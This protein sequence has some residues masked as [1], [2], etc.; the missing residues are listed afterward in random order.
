MLGAMWAPAKVLATPLVCALAVVSLAAC[1][2]EAEPAKSAPPS[3]TPT[4]GATELRA[5]PQPYDVTFASVA[6]H[7]AKGT[8]EATLRAVTRP[9]RTWMDSGFV[10][11]PWP[12]DGF[13]AAF[14][15]FAGGVESKARRDADLLTLRRTGSSLAEVIPARRQVKVSV[16]THRGHVI[17]ATARVDVRLL[18]LDQAG[19]R[20]RVG[21]RGDLYL[22]RVENRGWTIFGYDLEKSKKP[23]KGQG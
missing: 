22:T 12:R 5:Q 17:G 10:A 11:G 8:R 1:T 2:D 6:G 4:D 9:V 3:P 19:Q 15:P 13:D 20:A 18:T 23:Q 7:M 14:A 21:V 16:T